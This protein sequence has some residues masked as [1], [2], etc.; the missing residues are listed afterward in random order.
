MEI[1]QLR[2]EINELLENVVEHSNNYSGNRQIPSLEISFVLT[3]INKMQEALIILKHL[4]K[5]NEL[6][7]KRQKKIDA[8]Q[9]NMIKEDPVTLSPTQ[10]IPQEIIEKE[11]LT[12]QTE[13]EIKQPTSEIKQKSAKNIERLPITKLVDTF[14]LNDRYLYANELFKKEMSAFNEF[15]KNIDECSSLTEAE[16]LISKTANNLMWD[17]ENVHVL[18]FLNLVERRFL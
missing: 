4:I 15:V 5:E 1:E 14:S 8:F 2:K 7:I 9:S 16:T 11:P 12:I 3:K 17:K 18:S 6:E 13:V 10:A